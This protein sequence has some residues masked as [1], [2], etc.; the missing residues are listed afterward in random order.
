MIVLH[1][2]HESREA[3]EIQEKLEDLVVAHKVR[4]DAPDN[5]PKGVTLPVVTEGDDLYVGDAIEERLAELEFG[6][7][8]SRQISSDACYIDPDNP[9]ECF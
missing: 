4:Y 8:F 3:D 9:A 5:L 6:L 2:T 1:R 7:V